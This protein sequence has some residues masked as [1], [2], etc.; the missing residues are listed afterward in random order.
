[1]TYTQPKGMYA[2]DSCFEPNWEA[3]FGELR[4][5]AEALSDS[6][7][8]PIAWFFDDQRDEFSCKDWQPTFELVFFMPRKMQT[9]SFITANFDRE[10]VQ[11]WLDTWLKS[12]ID[13]WFGWE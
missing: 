13:H 3:T 10:T 4:A 7:N 12:Q 1:M 9:T 6:L 5:T 2:V 8:L 11:N